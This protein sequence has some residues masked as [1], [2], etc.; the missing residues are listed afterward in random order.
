MTKVTKT[1]A[2]MEDLAIG[3]GKVAQ[4]RGVGTKIDLPYTVAD[5]EELRSLDTNAYTKAR[6]HVGDNYVD[7][8]YSASA[9]E[10]I[11]AI[12]AA[13]YWVE[14]LHSP[15]LSLTSQILVKDTG[16]LSRV[17]A[18]VGLI[19]VTFEVRNAEDNTLATLY[20]DDGG[21]VEIAQ[22]GVSN[23]TNTNGELV[24]HIDT[25]SYVLIVENS[26][27]RFSVN[28]AKALLDA[29]SS[30][31]NSAHVASAIKTADGRSVEQRFND[32]P[33]EVDAAGTASDLVTAHNSDEAAHPELSAFIT[34]EA[35]RAE[36]A[37]DAA[38]VSSNV[39]ATTT[40]GLAATTSGDY[41]NVVSSGS[42]SFIDLFKNNAGSAQLIKTYPSTE[43][44]NNIATALDIVKTKVNAIQ[45]PFIGKLSKFQLN[46]DFDLVIS[47][48]Y[49]IWW[50][51]AGGLHSS[52]KIAP[53]DNYIVSYPNYMWF[54]T[55]VKVEGKCVPQQGSAT[56]FM[57][58]AND[59]EVELF[60]AHLGASFVDSTWCALDL[61]HSL[62]VGAK[63]CGI[64][65]AAF[66]PD[67]IEYNASTKKME[68]T[69]FRNNDYTQLYYLGTVYGGSVG[70]S[71][72]RI[73]L[74]NPPPLGEDAVFE[75]E[76][77]S[78]L[79]IKV[80]T[81]LTQD[82]VV[83]KVSSITSMVAHG[84][85]RFANTQE[86]ILLGYSSDNAGGSTGQGGI[87]IGACGAYANMLFK[88]PETFASQDAPL[89]LNTGKVGF[90]GSSTP[91]TFD[92]VTKKLQWSSTLVVL[93]HVIF[94]SG[95]STARRIKIPPGSIDLSEY[96][97]GYWVAYLDIEE[98][99]VDEKE[100]ID[101]SKIKIERYYLSTADLMGN[102][103][104]QLFSYNFGQL[105]H[106]SFP[107]IRG[108]V[109][110]QG[111]DVAPGS[112]LCDPSEIIVN[113]GGTPNGTTQQLEVL[114]KGN[115]AES[116]HY[117]LWRIVRQ[118]IPGINAD[119]W[120]SQR[121]YEV[122]LNPNGSYDV[123]REVIT[124][125]EN[126][127]AIREND[128]ADFMSG[129]AHGD[130]HTLWFY[131]KVDG[132]KIDP[133]VA[134]SY[135]GGQFELVQKSQL[136]EEGTNM[137][138][139]FAKTTRRML[140]NK[141]GMTTSNYTV[142]E[143]DAS[144]SAWYHTLWCVNRAY[145]PNLARAPLWEIEDGSVGHPI[146]HSYT[147]HAQAWG[148]SIQYECITNSK[149]NGTEVIPRLFFQ[150]NGRYNKFYFDLSQGMS[151]SVATGD[152][153]E[154]THHYMI[155]TNN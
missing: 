120:H 88:Y 109:L 73:K 20:L 12:N 112:A 79:I 75:L 69:F 36:A 108:S 93:A 133:E 15:S 49:E 139:N 111:S 121:A 130:E 35:D 65:T 67:K 23:K 44:V 7:Y 132:Q 50:A 118:P 76:R 51:D 115:K 122:A 113:V 107:P 32:L 124:G 149:L 146:I 72:K 123:L 154:S 10:G 24:F 6:L 98:L 99:T 21:L 17:E 152:I 137:V 147:N 52:T 55:R 143:K 97:G 126:D 54:D 59:P 18:F 106:K 82:L 150:N 84:V 63:I 41:F 129:T 86:I 14:A 110:W 85:R 56:E 119:V 22:N 43:G 90:S 144:I 61:Y 89:R 37:A 148:Q 134:G 11:K 48:D 77:Y 66:Y 78:A 16:N 31:T 100:G 153:I 114:Y 38:S 95:T 138:V 68:V 104:I 1:L 45:T 105:E 34:A 128:K 141:D 101:L 33:G 74:A 131:M 83:E 103:V 58:I 70:G 27:T 28:E 117:I 60:A 64:S 26:R 2:V 8:K 87:F 127:S 39:Y 116:N 4:T 29:H 71:S 91:P 96:T 13:G 40:A 80:P 30:S 25:G 47:S 19:G 3:T 62:D 102:N 94:P 136:F 155:T 53:M 9:T 92:P 42:A 145:S 140:I 151:N 57:V 125:G 142:M 135:R 5:K 46:G 81:D